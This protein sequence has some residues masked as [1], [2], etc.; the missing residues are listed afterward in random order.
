M[1]DVRDAGREKDERCDLQD[2]DFETRL[3]IK[4]VGRLTWNHYKAEIRCNGISEIDT[5][6][7]D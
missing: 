7:C 1:Q 4:V 2:E 3:A 6:L 5:E